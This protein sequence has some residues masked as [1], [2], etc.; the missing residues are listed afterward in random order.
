MINLPKDLQCLIYE[1]DP[2]YRELY[3]KICK[4]IRVWKCALIRSSREK[5]RFSQEFTLLNDGIRKFVIQYKNQNFIIQLPVDYPFS[6]PIV[7]KNGFKLCPYENWSSA[8]HIEAL[9]R[10]Y[11]VDNYCL[12]FCKDTN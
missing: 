5:K 9:I 8:M 4:D 6:I 7:Y 1:Y 10:S 12:K 2:T 11:E 3:T